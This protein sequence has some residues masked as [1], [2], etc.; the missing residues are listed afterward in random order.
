[1]V[2]TVFRERSTGHGEAPEVRMFAAKQV[3]RS[4]IRTKCAQQVGLSCAPK[5]LIA[6]SVTM[7]PGAYKGAGSREEQRARP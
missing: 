5:T 4:E 3:P 2:G 1:M 7:R 6:D